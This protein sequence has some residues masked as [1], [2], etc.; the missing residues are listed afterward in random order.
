MMDGPETERLRLR[1]WRDSDHDRL[2]TFYA[3]DDSQFVGGPIS[4]DDAWR[5]MAMFV[6]HWT[7][8]GFGNW[9]IEEKATGEQAGYAGLWQPFGWPE[10]EI[11][12][13]LFDG[14]RGKGYATEAAGAAR[15]H[16]YRK[17]G[18]TTAVSCIDPANRA[19]ELVAQR[20]GARREKQIN[21]R[22]HPTA[23]WRH[24]SPS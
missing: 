15:D 20:L 24:P 3:S 1:A 22:G 19:S 23:I 16:A 11:I 6:G 21:L 2:A 8:R 17:L 12:W 9:V 4:A 5:R 10:R 18:W 13:I 7:L 14:Y